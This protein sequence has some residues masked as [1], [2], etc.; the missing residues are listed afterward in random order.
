MSK[1]RSIQMIYAF[2]HLA[3]GSRVRSALHNIVLS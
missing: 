3:A 1:S 2:I